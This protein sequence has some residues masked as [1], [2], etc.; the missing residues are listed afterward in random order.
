MAVVLAFSGSVQAASDYQFTFG[1]EDD[2]NYTIDSVSSQEVF[3][4]TPGAGDPTLTL[5]LGSRYEI[6]IV[7]ALAHPLQILAKGANSGTDVVLLSQGGLSGTLESDAGVDWV[8]NGLASNAKVEFTVTQALLDAMTAG[9]RQPG[10]RCAVHFTMM[11]GNFTVEASGEGEGEGEAPL[12]NP[13][14]AAITPGDRIIALETA[15]AGL[16]APLGA[17]FPDDASGQMLVFDQTGVVIAVA[18]GGGQSTFLDLSTRLVD[19]GIGGPGTYD[20][21]GFLGF[22]LHPDY[23]TDPRV[24]TYSSEPAGSGTPDF[25]VADNTVE[26]H[27]VVA[28]WT[29]VGNAVDT[30]SRNELMRIEQ[31]Q[32]NHNGGCMRF[33]PDGYLYIGL[34]DGGAADDDPPGHSAGGNGQDLTSIL[35]TIVRIDVD[36]GGALSANG[37]YGIPLDNPFVG[38]AGLD[39]IY[40]YGFRNPFSFSFDMATGDL[41]VGDVG[42]NDIEEL[43]VVASGGNYGWNMKE[44]SFLFNSNGAGDGFVTGQQDVPGLIDPVAEYDH[45][46]GLAIQGGF[47]HHG[48]DPELAGLYIAGDFSRGFGAPDGRLF[49]LEPGS[50]TF[51]EFRI[52]FP[53][54]NLGLYVKGF[55]Q[56][57]EGNVYVCASTALAPAGSGGA[58]YK[59]VPANIDLPITG[60]YWPLAL[61]ALALGALGTGLYLRRAK[62]GS[63]PAIH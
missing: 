2:D 26:H 27:S 28:E 36:N 5:S 51:R 31:P 48:P 62:A 38:I 10:Y 63:V 34:G 20:E 8:D 24:Y 15:V 43:D 50:N 46:E 60:G 6:T 12:E 16:P 44:G 55:A 49:Y 41:L 14:L 40:A 59:I 42:Q 53:T 56:D 11:R 61:L 32:F 4:G 54:Q 37:K 45:D 35:G 19:L 25:E 33:G 17:V 47:V 29:V 52:G 13:I 22:A 23:P 58:V 3:S 39:E 21:R 7:N 9:G 1:D 30:G 57:L 18:S